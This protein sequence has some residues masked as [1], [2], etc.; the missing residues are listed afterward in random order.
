MTTLF[1]RTFFLF[2]LAF[3]CMYATGEAYQEIVS[4]NRRSPISET[5]VDFTALP[6][7]LQPV[8]ECFVFRHKKKLAVGACAVVASGVTWIVRP[9]YAMYCLLAGMAGPIVSFCTAAIQ[10]ARIEDINAA[11]LRPVIPR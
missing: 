1:F 5:R 6:D 11:M 10:D 8:Q 2:N 9:D 7:G 3:G 4:A